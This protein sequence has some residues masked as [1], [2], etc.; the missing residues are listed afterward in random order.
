MAT[1]Q[2]SDRKLKGQLRYSEK[3]AAEAAQ[4][5]TKAEEWLLP[6]EAGLLEAE[7]LERSWRFSQVKCSYCTPTY[8][9]YRI[10][11]LKA[12]TSRRSTAVVSMPDAGLWPLG[13]HRPRG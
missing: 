12:G 9:K 2:I 1:R 4:K 6:S 3:L 5:A 8:D 10:L 13:G 11:L 7:G